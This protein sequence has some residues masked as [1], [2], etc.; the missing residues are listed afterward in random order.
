[1]KLLVAVTLLTMVGLFFV[2]PV[3][4]FIA[5]VVPSVHAN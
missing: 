5:A 2:E 4:L 3:M 1:M